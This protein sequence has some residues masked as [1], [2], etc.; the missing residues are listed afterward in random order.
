MGAL[1]NVVVTTLV[2]ILITTIFPIG[3]AYNILAVF[4]LPG[5]SLFVPFK[6]LLQKMALKGH[7]ITVIN[8]FGNQEDIPN[9]TVIKFDGSIIGDEIQMIVGD[10]NILVKNKVKTQYF[11]QSILKHLSNKLCQILFDNHMVQDL[12]N[13]NVTF[14]VVIL[15]LFHTDCTYELARRF[16][17]AIIGFHASQML[18]WIPDRFGLTSNPAITDNSYVPFNMKMTFYERV[19]NALITWGFMFYYHKAMYPTDKRIIEKYFGSVESAALDNSVYS[20]SLYLS[21]THF[22]VNL[23]RLTLPN[24]I[25]I[26]GIHITN[27]KKLPKVSNSINILMNKSIRN[28]LTNIYQKK[29][30]NCVYICDYLLYELFQQIENYTVLL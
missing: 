5:R 10:L 21:N 23:P 8:P 6:P 25:E 29:L 17:S 16:K 13:S 2:T 15:N 30:R 12:Y 28:F 26:G 1:N 22:S 27:P 11:I 9:Y 19:W 7:N 24:I 4:L 18:S 14:D 3:E 20:T